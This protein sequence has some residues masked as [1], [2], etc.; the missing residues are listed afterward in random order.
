MLAIAGFCVFFGVFNPVPIDK[1]I[2]P[3]VGSDFIGAYS[4]WPRSIFLVLMTLAILGLA[5]A[6]HAYGVKRSGKG[7]GAA[8]HIHNAP[9]LLPIYNA[10]E[11]GLLD[12]YNIGLLLTG[13]FATL[14]GWIDRGIDWFYEKLVVGLTRGLSAAIRKAH[15]GNYSRYI[16]WSLAG[17]AVLLVWMSLF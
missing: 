4:G 6:N 1:L 2:A 10:A 17:I 9:V 12:P 5:V 16:V 7:I 3:I 15:S 11:K 14:C 8:D 13:W